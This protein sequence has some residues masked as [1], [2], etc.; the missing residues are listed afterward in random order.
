[1][2]LDAEMISAA[3]QIVLHL[4]DALL[5]VV[6]GAMDHNTGNEGNEQSRHGNKPVASS[7]CEA[8]LKLLLQPE[9]LV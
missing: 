8:E 9:I 7:A 5:H 6:R 2:S 3:P 1:M 4:F